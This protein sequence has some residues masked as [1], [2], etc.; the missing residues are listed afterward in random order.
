MYKKNIIKKNCNTNENLIK[1]NFSRPFL[2]PESKEPDNDD[3][4]MGRTGK[5][6]PL[7]TKESYYFYIVSSYILSI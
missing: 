1:V 6:R 3:E 2:F 4:R 7:V 5:F